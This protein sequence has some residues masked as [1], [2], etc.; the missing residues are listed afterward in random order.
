VYTLSRFGFNEMM[1]CRSRLRRLFDREPQSVEE[2]AQRVV[3]FFHQS[4]VDEDGKPACALVRLFKTHPYAELDEE[5]QAFARG[6]VPEVETVDDARCL[7]LLATQ[8]DLPEWRSRHASSGHK[9][10]PLTSEE[11]IGKAPMIA[12]LFKQ[13]GVSVSSIL[14]PNPTLL[15]DNLDTNFNV[16]H[17][18]RALG[19]PYIVAQ[20]EF[21][22]PHAIASV[23]GFGGMLASGELFAAIMFTKVPVSSAVADQ[24]KVIGLNLKLAMLP[25]ARKKLFSGQ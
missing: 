19:S 2:G 21:V 22:E 24:F 15:L 7:V 17:V 14:R 13:F 8:G 6:V 12:Q 9:A 5:L 16:F 20:K 25:I 1:D 11:M 3:E 4:F 23:L 10:I 18:A